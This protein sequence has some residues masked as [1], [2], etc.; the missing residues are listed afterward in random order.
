MSL[1]LPPTASS[2]PEWLRKCATAVNSLLK[3][4][5]VLESLP[6]APSGPVAGQVYFDTAL[7]KARVW[8]GSAWQALW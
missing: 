1:F 7:H 3:A 5:N 4:Q 2:V 6:S 8:D